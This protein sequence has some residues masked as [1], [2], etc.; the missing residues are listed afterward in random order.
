MATDPGVAL[1]DIEPETNV[2]VTVDPALDA[3]AV[4][5]DSI[6]SQEDTDEAT[7]VLATAESGRALFEDFHQPEGTPTERFQV[8][9]GA[10]QR[11]DDDDLPDQI[12]YVPP[13]SEYLTQLGDQFGETLDE[14]EADID[15]HQS[16]LRNRTGFYSV[17]PLLDYADDTELVFRFLCILINQIED[18]GGHGVFLIDSSYESE[19]NQIE[20]LFDKLVSVE[21]GPDGDREC[22]VATTI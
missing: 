2:L 7:I 10:I 14:L 13:V 22:K 20:V 16:A 8:I 3:R 12:K 19:I 4:F 11:P 1:A 18:A 5:L 17:G 15:G 6:T 21:V 9:D